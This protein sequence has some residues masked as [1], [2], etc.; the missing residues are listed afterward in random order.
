MVLTSVLS[1]F[2][3]R[4]KL[5][6]ESRA[7]AK[8]HAEFY[9]Q[10]REASTIATYN[11][12]YR[13]L[14]QF[15]VNSGRVFGSWS[16]RDV[17]SFIIWRAKQGVSENQLKQGLAV[18]SLLA[19][20]CGFESPAR[21]PVVAKVKL[22]AIKEANEGK[23]KVERIGMTKSIL[24]SIMKACYRRDYREVTPERRRF[25]LMKVFCFLGVR[26]FND[27][28]ELKRKNV[29]FREDGRVTVW[30]EKSKTDAKREGFEFVLTKKKILGVSVTRLVR[31]YFR[32]LG[33]IPSEAFI[34]P[35]FRRGKAV[36]SQAVSYNSARIQLNKLRVEL[37]LGNVTWHSGRIGAATEAARKKVSKNVI[38]K[39]GGW[40]SSAVD[41]YM[42][43]EDAGVRVG[44]AL[45]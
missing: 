2:V 10:G 14:V 20:V 33:D 45:L 30:V 40:R 16:E 29:E 3:L 1:V 12:E 37:D 39:G 28:H 42:R 6:G 38:M 17:V 7:E 41:V 43:V 27:I 25:L 13:K 8:E 21:S 9:L 4:A 15:G 18:V 11:T 5:E 19:E 35:V 32:S 23:R 26:R 36:W 22:A 44:D 34:F 24:E 31:W